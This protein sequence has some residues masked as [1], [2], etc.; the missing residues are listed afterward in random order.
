MARTGDQELV[1]MG[2]TLTA[3][4]VLTED[5]LAEYCRLPGKRPSDVAARGA[6]DDDIP[7][8]V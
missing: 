8:Y 3:R 2:V 6:D 1:D 7:P 4:D 5:E